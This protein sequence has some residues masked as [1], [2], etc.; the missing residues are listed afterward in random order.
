MKIVA[1]PEQV[2]LSF[3]QLEELVVRE[4]PTSGK[5]VVIAESFSGPI[6]LQLAHRGLNGLAAVVFVSSFAYRRLVGRVCF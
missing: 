6:A 5:Y 1:Y 4:L 3:Q 2:H